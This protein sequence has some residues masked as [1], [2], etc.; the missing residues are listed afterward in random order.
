M[1]FPGEGLNFPGARLRFLGAEATQTQSHPSHPGIP[2][3]NGFMAS[4]TVMEVGMTRTVL[5]IPYDPIPFSH[6]M[7][8]IPSTWWW[9]QL[10]FW[11]KIPS[12][13]GFLHKVHL[14]L[15]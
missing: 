13:C 15:D 5:D 9:V 12:S 14:S 2:M 11:E 7:R 4:G 10:D 6:E 3:V 1:T 8:F